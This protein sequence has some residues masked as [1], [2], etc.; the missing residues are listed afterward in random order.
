MFWDRYVFRQVCFG[1]VMFQNR[2]VFR[3]AC[4]KIDTFRDRCV[5]GQVCRR[6]VMFQDRYVFGQVCLSGVVGVQGVFF[7]FRGVLGFFYFVYFQLERYVFS[8]CGF[9]YLGCANIGFVY[10]RRLENRFGGF[11]GGGIVVFSFISWV[12]RDEC[13]WGGIGFFSIL[14]F[15]C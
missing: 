2:C 11:G 10:F 9:C 13:I 15:Y 8:V 6:V 5:F 12:S 14:F 1:V 3:Q 7:F 4:F